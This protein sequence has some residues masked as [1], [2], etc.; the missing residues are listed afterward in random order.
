MTCAGAMLPCNAVTADAQAR[1]AVED[2]PACLVPRSIQ[3]TL[4]RNG[5]T[6]ATANMPSAAL[7]PW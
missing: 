7:N 3:G 1:P 5:A 2:Q 4:L 6:A